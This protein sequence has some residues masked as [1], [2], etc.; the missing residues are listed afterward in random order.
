MNSGLYSFPEE[1]PVRPNQVLLS[2]YTVPVAVSSVELSIPQGYSSHI[3]ELNPI[4]LSSSSNL[5][6]QFSNDGGSSYDSTDANYSNFGIIAQSGGTVPYAPSGMAPTG[7][8]VSYLTNAGSSGYSRV[9]LNGLSDPDLGANGRFHRVEYRG[10]DTIPA[11]CVLISNCR[12]LKTT[13]R[14]VSKIKLLPQ[15]GNISANSTI[16]MWGIK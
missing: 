12:Y 6:L 3:I 7:F 16:R 13:P 9:E 8:L 11:N 5:M 15:T 4:I 10:T 1:V 14:T 2:N